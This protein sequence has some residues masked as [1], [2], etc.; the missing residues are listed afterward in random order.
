MT[1][2]SAPRPGFSA[3]VHDAQRVFR[4]VMT[5]LSE[6]G[7]V[8]P[9]DAG[10]TPPDGLLPTSAAVLL[11]LADYE[12]PIWLAPTLRS[13]AV[14][15]FLRFHTGAALVADPTRAAFAVMTAD[16]FEGL[17]GLPIGTLEYPDRSATLILEVEALAEAGP[18][19]LA[20]PGT[21]ERAGSASHRCRRRSCRRFPPA[22][23]SSRVGS[24]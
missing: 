17:E 4:A 2:M 23:R 7:T 21:R 12:T 10:L 1:A 18:L 11:A 5:A 9:L 24:T 20:G 16:A 8:V 14:E 19:A 13:S 22:T 6:P 15:S 3:P